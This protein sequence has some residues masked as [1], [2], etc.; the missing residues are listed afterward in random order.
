M[1]FPPWAESRCRKGPAPPI[2]SACSTAAPTPGSRLWPHL[3]SPP[4]RGFTYTFSAS[5]AR[6]L[7]QAQHHP[8]DCPQGTLLGPSGLRQRSALP[9]TWQGL[10]RKGCVCS[11]AR[12]HTRIPVFSPPPAFSMPH[13]RAQAPT[14]THADTCAHK[15]THIHM[16][17]HTRACTH[18]L[19]P[20]GSTKK[21]WA[22]GSGGGGEAHILKFTP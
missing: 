7:R 9:Q 20:A 1:R 14:H 11:T 18:Y 17:A 21:D 3:V 15:H 4:S 5:F 12:P 19:F 6:L 13:T 8:D 22:E 2:A 16:C 10:R